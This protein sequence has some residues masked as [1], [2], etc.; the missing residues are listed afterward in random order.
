LT[1]GTHD[2]V[3]AWYDRSVTEDHGWSRDMYNVE[4]LKCFRHYIEGLKKDRDNW[5]TEAAS[6]KKQLRNKRGY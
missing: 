3:Q 1:H 6:W 4:C 5:Q 2:G